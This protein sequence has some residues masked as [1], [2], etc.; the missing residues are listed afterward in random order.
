MGDP[1][2]G[3]RRLGLLEDVVQTFLPY[4]SFEA[5]ALALDPKRLG[6]QRVEADQILRALEDPDYG[7]QN[8]PAVV[9]WRGYVPAL[10]VYRNVMIREWIARGYHNTMPILRTGGNPRLPL[11][12]GWADFHASHRSNLLRKD[13][14]FYGQHGWEEPPDIPYLWPSKVAGSPTEIRTRT[15]GGTVFETA[16]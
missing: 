13:P 8:H 10:R 4:S 7:W 14:E 9:M 5:S 12:I 2:R 16:A 15:P 6:K 11:W 3:D 1:V